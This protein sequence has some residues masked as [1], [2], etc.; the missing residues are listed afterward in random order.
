MSILVKL[1]TEVMTELKLKQL[2]Y[3]INTWKRMLGFMQ[4]EN[5]HLKNRLSDVLKDRFNKNMLDGVE[6]F[7]TNFIKEDEVI[8]LLKSE[9]A[10]VE[11]I[12]KWNLITDENI[13]PTSKRIETV[14]NNIDAAEKDFSKINNDFNKYLSE[15]I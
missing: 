1:Q 9:V 12:L 13:F 8:G 15:N 7:Q 14:R 6:F 10:E 11:N 5:V 3:E 4:E 2:R